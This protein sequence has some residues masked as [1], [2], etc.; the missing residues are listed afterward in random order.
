QPPSAHQGRTRLSRRQATR[1][2]AA[3]VS[4]ESSRSSVYGSR[5]T[6]RLFPL[7]MH[8]II[9][10]DC[11]DCELVDLVTYMKDT[12]ADHRHILVAIAEDDMHAALSELFQF[13]A[14]FLHGFGLFLRVI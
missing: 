10:I 5:R 7:D 2:H 4:A 12:L 6:W 9:R 8:T 3:Q 1:P 14:A 13:H 11:H